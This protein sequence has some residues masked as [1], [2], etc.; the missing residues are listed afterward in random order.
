MNLKMPPTMADEEDYD[1]FN[2]KQRMKSR[3]KKEDSP[4]FL[5]KVSTLHY[6]FYITY[7]YLIIL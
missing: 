2:S 3:S 1:F 7:V 4:L 5:R 6:I